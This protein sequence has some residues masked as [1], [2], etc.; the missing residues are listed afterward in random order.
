[1]AVSRKGREIVE[2]S[3]LV[4]VNSEELLIVRKGDGK[5]S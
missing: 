3:E 2:K 4:R 1:M 5:I